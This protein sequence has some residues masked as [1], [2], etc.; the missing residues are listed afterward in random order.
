MRRPLSRLALPGRLWT[1]AL[2]VLLIWGPLAGASELSFDALFDKETDGRLA[3]DLEWRPGHAELR[4]TWDGGDGEKVLLLDVAKGT[5]KILTEP[6]ALAGESEDEAEGIHFLPKGDALLYSLG[7][8]LYRYAMDGGEILQLT[9]TE[10]AEEMV[11]VSPD[12]SRLAY[13][14]DND[15]YALSLGGGEERRLTDDGVAEEIFNG[16]TDWVYWEEIWGR[17]ATASWWN[18]DASALAYYHIDDREVAIYPLVDTSTAVPTVQQQRYPKSGTTLP[19]VEIR[20]AHLGGEHDGKTVTLDTGD[21][22]DVYLAR[23]HWHP[24]NQRLVVQRLNRDQTRID[25]LL[26]KAA[27]GS[28]SDWGHDSWPTWI[29]LS[30]DFTFLD[31]GRFL[32]SSEKSGWKQLYLHGK[33]GQEIRQLTPD[34]WAVTSLN[35]VDPAGSR[36][37]YTAYSTDTLGAAE[38]HVFVLNLEDGASPRQLTSEEGWHGARVADSGHWVHTFSDANTPPVQWVRHLDD[39]VEHRLPHR[40]PAPEVA[41]LPSWR[42]FTLDGPDG[43]KLPAQIMLPPTADSGQRH[44]VIMYHYGGP[45]SQVVA[46]RWRDN[47]LRGLWHK[48]MAQQGYVLMS[49]DNQASTYFGKAGED[50]LHRR[51]GEVELAGQLA[52]VDY[53]KTLPWVDTERLGLWGWSG[54]GSH[55]LYSLLRG[56]GVW[57][58]GISGAPVTDWRYYDAIWM[59]RYLDHPEDNEQGY[60]ESAPI[61]YA[62]KLQDALLLIHGTADDNVHP[63]N[64]LEMSRAFIEAGVPFDLAIYPGAMHGFSS[65]KETGRRHLFQRMTDFFDRHLQDDSK[66][67]DS[68]Q[69]ATDE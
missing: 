1:V 6:Q 52:G 19:K 32:W 35:W 14:R 28:C 9:E 58:A 69:T 7:G 34:G 33:D 37:V 21:D 17:D 51:F 24:D 53:L 29:N 2:L 48:W 50:L 59:E 36:L 22:P 31:D 43:S 46:K 8:D 49:V 56:P 57:K 3:S 66:P 67:D 54:G 18:E 27:D 4:M 15:L 5:H 13:V 65:F 45:A 68:N 16:I 10:A 62:S 26:C 38:R 40:P 11:E 64:S 63:Q 42:H 12:G 60:V 44:P 39:A 25:L 47:D 30:S 20:V 55:T 41:G 61:T 23:V